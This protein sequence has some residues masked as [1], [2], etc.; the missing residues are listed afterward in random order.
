MGD[1]DEIFIELKK[2]HGEGRHGEVVWCRRDGTE[3]WYGVGGT[4]RGGGMVSEGRHGEV[5]GCR[6]PRDGTGRLVLEGLE[7]RAGLCAVVSLGWTV[8]LWSAG[9]GEMVQ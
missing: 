6:R 7:A 4:A 5:V 8:V 9:I 1:D 2:R 3:R